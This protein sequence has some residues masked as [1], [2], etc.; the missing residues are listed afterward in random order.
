M[1]V[2]LEIS[3][4]SPRGGFWGVLLFFLFFYVFLGCG[5][6]MRLREGIF[7]PFSPP[8]SKKGVYPFHPIIAYVSAGAWC[9]GES[10]VSF[11]RN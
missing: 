6:G 11:E 10:Q 9:K 4:H 8:F 3:S 7:S 2:S 5:M 1:H